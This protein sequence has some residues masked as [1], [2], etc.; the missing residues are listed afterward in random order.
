MV[1]V[2]IAGD[3]HG[4]LPWPTSRIQSVGASDVTTILHVGDFGLWPGNSAKRYLQVIEKTCARAGVQ[5]QVTPGNH[6][7]WA[8]LT[9]L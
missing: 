9:A 3:W 6:E 7:G 1:K 4:N 2:V 5:L 8:R